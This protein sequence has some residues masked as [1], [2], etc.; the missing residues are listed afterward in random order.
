[1]GTRL[2]VHLEWAAGLHQ[3]APHHR[4]KLEQD[5]KSHYLS[6]SLWTETLQ[7]TLLRSVRFG[8]SGSS[9]FRLWCGPQRRSS[10]PTSS[11]PSSSAHGLRQ[12]T[13]WRLW[14]CHSQCPICLHQQGSW[15]YKRYNILNKEQNM[16]PK[17]WTTQCT[18]HPMALLLPSQ[19]WKAYCCNIKWTFGLIENDACVSTWCAVMG[20]S[21]SL[22][23][24]MQ[25]W[26]HKRND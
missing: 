15:Y 20:A 6:R 16:E 8:F 9:C 21:V 25:P 1:M 22:K 23:R 19:L 18:L 10:S 3:A 7:V 26:L 2:S 11:R 14:A 5:C 12:G 13:R 24:S 4:T 17:N